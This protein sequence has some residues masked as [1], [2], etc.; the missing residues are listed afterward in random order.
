M[1]VSIMKQFK[2]DDEK[3]NNFFFGGVK[4]IYALMAA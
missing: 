2:L 4:N 3:F 1:P